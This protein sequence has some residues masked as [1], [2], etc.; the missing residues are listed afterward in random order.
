[1]A[2]SSISDRFLAIPAPLTIEASFLVI[3]RV[4]GLRLICCCKGTKKIDAKQAF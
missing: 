1:M 4:L 2:I 3:G